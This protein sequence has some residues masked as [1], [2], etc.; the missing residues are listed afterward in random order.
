M[1]ISYKEFYGNVVLV[2]GLTSETYLGTLFGCGCYAAFKLKLLWGALRGLRPLLGA[3]CPLHGS[4]AQDAFHSVCV[5]VLMWIFGGLAYT[6]HD[7]SP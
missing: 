3:F 7:R 4:S 6:R 5:C 1:L 2:V